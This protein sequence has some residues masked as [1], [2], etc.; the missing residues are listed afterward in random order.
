MLITFKGEYKNAQ[1]CG[2]WDIFLKNLY[3]DD[4]EFM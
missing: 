4:E 3:A 1:K 2:N